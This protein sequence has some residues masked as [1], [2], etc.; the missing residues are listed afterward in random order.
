MHKLFEMTNQEFKAR[1]TKYQALSNCWAL[2]YGAGGGGVTSFR[3]CAVSA[4]SGSNGLFQLCAF[5]YNSIKCYKNIIRLIRSTLPTRN[6]F[7]ILLGQRP[8][9]EQKAVTTPR[10]FT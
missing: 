3:A 7:T 8:P 6:Y 10:E 1:E 9:G 5:L 4:L 2:L